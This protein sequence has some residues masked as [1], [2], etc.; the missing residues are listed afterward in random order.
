MAHGGMGCGVACFGRGLPDEA[1][2]VD[3]ACTSYC[4][5]S[6]SGI[7]QTSAFGA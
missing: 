1:P 5:R 3:S 6:V 2:A 4:G 7:F